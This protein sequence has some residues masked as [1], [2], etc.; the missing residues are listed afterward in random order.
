MRG[1]S[2]PRSRALRITEAGFATIALLL[3]AKVLGAQMLTV[4]AQRRND[5]LFIAVSNRI[6]DVAEMNSIIATIHAEVQRV[7]PSALPADLSALSAHASEAEVR[8]RDV[9]ARYFAAR[10]ARVDLARLQDY[11]RMVAVTRVYFGT[12]QRVVA[13]AQRGDDD[14]A[15]VLLHDALEPTRVRQSVIAAGL[16]RFHAARTRSLYE[17]VGEAR[18]REVRVEFAANLLVLALL[19]VVRRVIIARLRQEDD[20]R[21]EH[22]AVLAARNRDLDEFAHRVAHDLKGLVNPITGYASL[23]S[24]APHDSGRV[25]RYAERISRKT[26]EVVAMVDELLRLA[27]AGNVSHGPTLLQPV[28][29]SVLEQFEA[30]VLDTDARVTMSLPEVMLNVGEVPLREVLQ[31]LIQNSLKYR[32]HD[33]VPTLALTAA[34]EDDMVRITLRDNGVGMST[35]VLRHAHEPFFRAPTERDVP[36]SGLGLAIV[37]RIATAH[38]GGFSVEAT[39]GEGTTVSLTLPRWREDDR[40]GS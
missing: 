2:A 15:R 36:G 6:E 9:G 5:E 27:R 35:A 24:E 23:I 14:A 34:T 30:E 18:R 3:L 13:L 12:L 19:L 21:A 11:F 31:N 10:E 33:R 22:L 1:P 28:A 38:G 8:F 39:E 40:R 17:L 25:T 29:S 4:Y 26:D 37:N 32:A 7:M 16:L 20:Q